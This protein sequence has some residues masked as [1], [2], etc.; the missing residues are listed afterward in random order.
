[1]LSVGQIGTF[2]SVAAVA[3]ASYSNRPGYVSRIPF[4][5]PYDQSFLEGYSV[6]KHI[7]GLGPY[8]NR[9]SFGIGRD[10][11]DACTVDQ[12]IMIRRH[13][14]RYPQSSDAE[15]V[16]ATLEK[17]YGSGIDTWKGDLTFLNWW[18][19]YVDDE[20]LYGL[21][22]ETGPYN[23]LLTTYKHG[24]EYRVRYGHLWDQDPGKKIPMWTSEYE[25]VIQTARK[26]GEGFFGWN[27]TDTVALN[28]I[29]ESEI[30]GANSLTPECPGDNDTAICD[31]L[32][33]DL[34]AFRVAAD[35]LNTQNPGLDLNSTDV[36]ELMFMSVFELNVRGYSDWINAFTLDEWKWFGYTQDLDFYYCAGPGDPYYKAVGSVYAN[37]SLTLLNQGPE[38]AQT[39][40]F[41]FAHDTN[42]TPILAALGIASPNEDLPLDKIPFPSSYEIGNIMPMGGHLTLERMKCNA[43]AATEEGVYVRAVLNEAVVPFND[44]QEG[45]GFSCSLGNYTKMLN[46][47]LPDFAA[48]CKINSTVPQYLDF[49][50]NYNTS[51]AYDHQGTA[52]IPYQGDG[53]A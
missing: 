29:S 6:L 8:S 23:G 18:T 9:M 21:E 45:P 49:W 12:V 42:I 24:A 2:L 26:F 7:G 34:P 43:T 38:E 22:T 3:A 52:Y 46:K 25:R 1:M 28:V 33:Q 40:Y 36:F 14:E 4:A 50:W 20:G 31:S 53:W 5:A 13:G 48:E 30:M 47:K 11:P 19:Y 44:C 39:I 51:S 27:Y 15:S 37:A 17:L 35:R 10:P 41:N 16:E 32:S